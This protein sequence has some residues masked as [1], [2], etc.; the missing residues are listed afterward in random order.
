M[1]EE[2]PA[3]LGEFIVPRLFRRLVVAALG[4]ACL[5]GSASAA[6]A[7]PA[8]GPA[9]PVAALYAAEQAGRPALADAALRAATLTRGLAALYDKAKAV[10][11]ATGDVLIDFDAV[12]NSQ[13][14]EVKSYA[15][16][17]ERRDATHAGVVATIDPG[18]WL[19]ASPRENV[20]R[21]TLVI[22]GGRWRID[23]VSGV[24]GPHAWSLRDVLE[25]NLREP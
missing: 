25:H 8:S 9:A 17:V 6:R 15:L 3:T 18:D 12:T 21:F 22:E 23:D 16:K 13:G 2:T 7:K 19:R 10:E 1:N 5:L 20:I 4:A 14:A 24:A 11:R